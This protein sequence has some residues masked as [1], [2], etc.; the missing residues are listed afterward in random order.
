[1]FLEYYGLQEQPFGVTPDPRFLFSSMTHREALASLMVGIRENRGFLALVAPPGMGKTTL[2]FHLMRNLE[3]NARTVFLFQTQCDS[4]E[5]IRYILADMGIETQDHDVVKMHTQLNEALVAIARS[6]KQF[7]L[8]ID[9]AQNLSPAALETVRLLSDFETTRS[10]LMQIILAGQPQLAEKLGH[11][12]LLQLS[13]RISIMSRLSVLSKEETGEYI[14]HRLQLAGYAGGRL[15]SPA[16]L[17][18]IAEYSGG[19][20]RNINNLCFNALSWGCATKK[21]VIDAEILREVGA[22]LAL[23]L[24]SQVQPSSPTPATQRTEDIAAPRFH[25]LA[26]AA[27]RKWIG[28]AAVA[29]ALVLLSLLSG[30]LIQSRH[31]AAAVGVNPPAPVVAAAAPVGKLQQAQPATALPAPSPT[32]ASKAV[33][34]AAKGSKP[35]DETIVVVEPNQALSRITRQYFGRSEPALLDQILQLNPSIVNPDH[36]E[37]GERIRLP[38]LRGQSEAVS[39]KHLNPNE[40]N[41]KGGSNLE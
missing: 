20:P 27:G 22:E 7:V 26:G 34:P 37:V 12:D 33:S 3:P 28:Q 23:N 25:Q 11:P 36:I 32:K 38:R 21:K 40:V 39:V 2:L 31:S 17:D 15:F 41:A 18:L 24:V 6:G 30:Y 35:D 8:I 19:I 5:L 13:Q 29:A 14:N 10:K 1:M 4:R 16:A 9:E